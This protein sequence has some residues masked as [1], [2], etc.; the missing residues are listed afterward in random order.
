MLPKHELVTRFAKLASGPV[1]DAMDKLKLPNGVL[2]AS[3]VP[4]D[5]LQPTVAGIACTLKQEVI[6]PDACKTGMKSLHREFINE[7]AGEDD[8]AIID[9]AGYSGASSGGGLVSIRAKARGI[10]AIVVYGAYRDL[11]E[12]VRVG[13]PVFCTCTSP[14][15]GNGV[16]NT[17][18]VQVPLELCGVTVRPGDV[19]VGDS[20]GL[21][22]VPIEHAE[23]VL[24]IAEHTILV[25]A[26]T[27]E[28][29][30]AGGDYFLSRKQAEAELQAK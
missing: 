12:A 13:M 25:E 16:L 17:T 22:C 21:V 4:A 10:R 9:V 1:S 18:G 14:K 26:R 30:E 19:L 27:A 20:T 3:I 29:L 5:R 15:R 23:E 8:I 6:P 7:T 24:A 11:D 2:P 28:L